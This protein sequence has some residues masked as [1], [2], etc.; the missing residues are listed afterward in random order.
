VISS[1]WFCSD[2]VAVV[3]AAASRLDTLGA[4]I[5]WTLSARITNLSRSSPQAANIVCM[6]NGKRCIHIDFSSSSDALPSA[7][8]FR[9]FKKRE[10][11]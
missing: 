10:G 7:S 6:F 11:H 8:S 9:R 4:T 5:S 2:D 3:V 1:I